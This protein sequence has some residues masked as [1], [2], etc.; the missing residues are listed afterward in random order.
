KRKGPA[1]KR[2]PSGA[3]ERMARSP[4]TLRLR[5]TVPDR[6][7]YTKRRFV[8]NP[9]MRLPC[10]AV[11]RP[12]RKPAGVGLTVTGRPAGGV[13]GGEMGTGRIR[14]VEGSR[15]T[16]PAVPSTTT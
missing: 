6:T 13:A 9:I 5:K 10:A 12:A 14:L 2:E 15:R 8:D 16:R 1:I 4:V 7:S 11:T 3:A